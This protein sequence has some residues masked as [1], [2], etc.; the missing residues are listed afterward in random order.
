MSH[1][2]RVAQLS[3]TPSRRDGG[4]FF[5]LAG[6]LPALA[7]SGEGFL[8]LTAFGARDPESDVDLP[9]WS[10]VPTQTFTAWPPASFAYAPGLVPAV[11]TFAPDLLHVHGLWSHASVACLAVARRDRKPYVVSPHGMLDPGALRFSRWKKQIASALFQRDH[12]DRAAVLHAL[13]ATEARGIREAGYTGPVAILPNG[14]NLPTAAPDRTSATKP[15][16]ARSR[17]LL[18]LGRIHPKKGLPALIEAWI[19]FSAH[20]ALG[21]NWRLVIAGWNEVAHEE[22]L[23]AQV[24]AAQADDRVV[25]AGPLWGEAKDAALGAADAFILPSLSEGLPMSVL[26]AW[27]RGKPALITPACNLPEGLAAG[28]ALPITPDAAGIHQG[29]ER[30]ARL[31]DAELRSMGISAHQ[32]VEAKF[33]WPAI[34]ANMIRLYQSVARG[35][36]PPPDLLARDS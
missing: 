25:F 10:P 28:A 2:L 12:L 23:R 32:L 24:A 3:R 30:L 15:A 17:T 8:S 11:R 19:P 7:R 18:Y 31:D 21:A 9:Q 27:A 5:A 1:P 35:Q 6:L 20:G 36:P 33:A 26:E 34:A 29:L 22:A 14:V 13:S 4:I 16:S